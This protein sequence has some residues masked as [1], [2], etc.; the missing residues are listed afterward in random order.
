MENTPIKPAVNPLS[1]Y[2]RQAAI[3]MKL[4]SNGRFWPDGSLD[5]PVTGEVPVYPMTAKDE[6]TLRTPDALMNGSGV[7]DVIHSCC[8]SIA[9]P[10]KMPSVD[11]DAVLIGI[12]IASYGHEMNLDTNCPHCKA[13][14][15]HVADLRVS[16][17]NIKCPDYAGKIDVQDL[18][19]KLRPQAYF[20][21][22]RRNTIAFEE[23]RMT[24]ALQLPDDQDE[25]RIKDISNS[26]S[27]LIQIGIDTVVDSTEYIE[28][29]DGTHVV[30]PDFI[31]EFYSNA[32]GGVVRGLQE[33]L[34]KFNEDAAVKPLMV[35]CTSCTKEYSIPLTFDYANFFA[36]GS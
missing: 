19:V 20:G 31:R 5:L 15:T 36:Q 26:M 12:R 8:P 17:E 7:V 13:E 22:N 6:I 35:A 2:F 4:P 9:D 24:R 25:K 10:W 34:S 14:N 21:V 33:Q 23:E 3:Y 28:L 16:L 30:E 11:V 27:R 1:K 18:K 32:D 29:A